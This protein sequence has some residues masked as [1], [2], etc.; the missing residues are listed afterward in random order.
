MYPIAMVTAIEGQ[1]TMAR[2]ALSGLFIPGYC[3]GYILAMVFYR[4][5]A[6]TYKEGK[7]GEVY[8]GLVPVLVSCCAPGD[9]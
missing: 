8:S 1:P 3:F 4:A 5:F 9:H 2:S 6:G 7:A